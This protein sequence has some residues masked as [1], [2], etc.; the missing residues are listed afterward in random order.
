MVK[1]IITEHP[2]LEVSGYVKA[3][4]RMVSVER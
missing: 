4:R 3:R 2:T 1:N